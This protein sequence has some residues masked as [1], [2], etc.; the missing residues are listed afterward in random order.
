VI[1]S[2][3]EPGS[4]IYQGWV[5]HR[6]Y[7]PVPHSLTYRLFMMY[8]DLSELPDLFDP[9]LFW[10]ARTWA[11]ACFNRRNYHGDKA[12]PLD[13]AVR[14]T[15]LQVTGKHSD[16]PI[17]LLTHLQYWGYCFNPVSLYYVFDRNDTRPETI[18]AEITNTP[19]KERR[20]LVLS[21]TMNHG[22]GPIAVYHFDKDFHVSPFWP[23]DHHYEWRFQTPGETLITHFK[24]RVE[25]RLVFDATLSMKRF[26][27]N[28]VNMRRVLMRHPFMTLKVVAGIHWQALKL[29]WKRAGFHPHPN[30]SGN[31]DGRHR[32]GAAPPRNPTLA[33][34]PVHSREISHE[35]PQ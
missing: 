35:S 15:I 29:Y 34:D 32:S 28:A 26:P 33:A 16:G 31:P 6:R 19:W 10:S 11:P 25:D 3:H 20:T 2:G 1:S 7:S 24:N 22:A 27:V 9:Y 23:L 18:V 30:H 12:V 14:N 21:D 8:L 13:E 17:R 5:R 4:Y